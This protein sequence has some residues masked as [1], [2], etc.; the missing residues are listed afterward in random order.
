MNN[1]KKYKPQLTQLPDCYK[2]VGELTCPYEP[3]ENAYPRYLDTV[4]NDVKD[5]VACE[6][7]CTFYEPFVCRAFAFYPSALQCFI[8]GDDRG[9]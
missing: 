9:T 6:V 8:S 7:Q 2:I 1:N 5:E 3:R 4:V